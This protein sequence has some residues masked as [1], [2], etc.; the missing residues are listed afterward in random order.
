MNTK[1]KQDFKPFLNINIKIIY[2]LPSK[3][4]GYYEILI[5]K[6]SKRS[7]NET[8]WNNL[9]PDRPSWSD[10]YINRIKNKKSK[11][12]ADDQFKLLHVSMSRKPVSLENSRQQ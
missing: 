1:V 7:H 11:K 12:I 5:K 8:Y 3:A 4:R 2:N 9:F 10:I 6:I